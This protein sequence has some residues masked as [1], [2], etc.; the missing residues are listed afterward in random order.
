MAGGWPDTA[1]ISVAVRKDTGLGEAAQAGLDHLIETGVY[2]EILQ[3]WGL[4]EEG[5]EASALNPPGLKD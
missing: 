1:H 2:G 4:T 5:I 3:G